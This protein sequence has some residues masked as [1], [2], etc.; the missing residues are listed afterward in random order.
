MTAPHDFVRCLPTPGTRPG[1]RPGDLLR[2]LRVSVKTIYVGNL[3]PSTTDE[4]LA[5]VFAPHGEVV[6]ARCVLDRVTGEGRGFGLVTMAAT[7][8]HAAVAALHDAE[9][10]GRRLRVVEH[11]DRREGPEKWVPHGAGG[12]EGLV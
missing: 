12:G 5:A 6:S 1:V 7:E 4:Q 10:N 11:T 9:F 2:A 3:P 8:V